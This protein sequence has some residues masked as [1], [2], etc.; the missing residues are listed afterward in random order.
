[1]TSLF[2]NTQEVAFE[3]FLNFVFKKKNRSISWEN[4]F[5]W[6]GYLVSNKKSCNERPNR[7]QHR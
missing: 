7:E 6:S 2:R 3:I 4:N 5:Y 1:M